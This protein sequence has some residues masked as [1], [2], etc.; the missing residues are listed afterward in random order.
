MT[1]N[2]HLWPKNGQNFYKIFG[3]HPGD[4]CH[5]EHYHS[6]LYHV[7]VG[8]SGEINVSTTA[9]YDLGPHHDAAR[10]RFLSQIQNTWIYQ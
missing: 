10:V 8:A 3:Q 5:S 2:G 1:K 4:P 6:A 7:V 9:G